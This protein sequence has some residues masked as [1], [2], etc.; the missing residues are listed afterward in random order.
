MFINND[1]PIS[2][3]ASWGYLALCFEQREYPERK[4]IR[5]CISFIKVQL[6]F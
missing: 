5:N 6:E 2:L 3:R 1:T 4:S